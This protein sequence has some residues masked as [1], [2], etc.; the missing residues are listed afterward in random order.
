MRPGLKSWHFPKLLISL[1]VETRPFAV[2]RHREAKKA[3]RDNL[4]PFDFSGVANT[5]VICRLS[6]SGHSPCGLPW[7]NFTLFSPYL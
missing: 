3:L 1:G 5:T 6:L 2:Q 4:A 7:C